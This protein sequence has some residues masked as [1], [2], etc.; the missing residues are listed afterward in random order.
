MYDSVY[1]LNHGGRVFALE[2]VTS[3]IDTGSTVVNG[4][5]AEFE[6]FLFRQF[7]TSGDHNGNRTGGSYLF[8]TVAVVSLHDR[9]TVLG[10]YAR[11]ECE[12]TGVACHLF[13]DSRHTHDG[14]AIAVSH[15]DSFHQVGCR[16][17][18]LFAVAGREHDCHSGSIVTDRIFDIDQDVTVQFR[19][20]R[21]TGI[22]TEADGLVDV[23]GNGS[24][25]DTARTHDTVGILYEGNDIQVD[26]FQT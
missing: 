25:Q 3:H 14:D 24:L 16:D 18:F 9:S 17:G 8:E 7:L 1:G 4:V 6:C 22:R 11:C 5:V 20:D 12:V 15:I 26:T 21:R 2:D 19:Q 10:A 23:G 13:A